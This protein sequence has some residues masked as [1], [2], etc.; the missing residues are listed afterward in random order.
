LVRKAIEDDKLRALIEAGRPSS[1]QPARKR[2]QE[3]VWL[4]L[5]VGIAIRVVSTVIA[6]LILG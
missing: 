2:W 1:V 3:N 5:I 6:N 4:Y